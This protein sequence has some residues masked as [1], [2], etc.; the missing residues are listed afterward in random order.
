M[1]SGADRT[2]YPPAHQILSALGIE[3]A[4]RDDEVLEGRVL[5]DPSLLAR[6]A[7]PSSTGLPSSEQPGFEQ[8]GIG[9]TG[10]GA[11]ALGVGP[12]VP[13]VDVLAGSCVSKYLDGDWMATADVWLHERRPL[14]DGPIT[15]EARVLRTGKRSLVAAVEVFSAGT[16]AA[17]G[18]VEFSRI[19]REASN[20]RGRPAD[21]TG[22]WRRMGTGPLLDQPV[23]RACGIRVIDAATGLTEVDQ[24]GFVANSIGTLQ[25]G[26]VAMLADVSAAAIVGP[27]ARTVDLQ[28]RFLAQTGVGPARATAEIIRVDRDGTVV[29]VEVRDADNNTL[30]GWAI[31]RVVR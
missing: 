25:G 6:A 30:V 8:S 12:L 27:E 9:Q 22:E 14:G 29:R 17:H 24:S 31:C 4:W 11:G 2:T 16:P 1:T 19:R 28:F 23:E 13:I 21:T 26:V 3:L 20:H 5:V 18:S 15:V 10:A 7:T